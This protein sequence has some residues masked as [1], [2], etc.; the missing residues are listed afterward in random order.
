MEITQLLQKSKPNTTRGVRQVEGPLL[1]LSGAGSG[2]TRV[3][4]YRLPILIHHHGGF[5]HTTFGRPSL[6]KLQVR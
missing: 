4:T 1:L 5:T 3:I 2:K 6:I